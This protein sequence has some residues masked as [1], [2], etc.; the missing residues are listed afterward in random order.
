M[1]AGER[2]DHPLDESRDIVAALH[3]GPLVDD[4]LIELAVIERVERDRGD[5]DRRRR[6]AEHGRR[7]HVVRHAERGAADLGRGAR[8][9]SRAG[10][11]ARRGTGA[12]R[13]LLRAGV[14]SARTVRDRDTIAQP[15]HTKT[16]S[17]TAHDGK[18]GSTRLP[19]AG[20]QLLAFSFE[21]PAPTC[22]LPAE[23]IESGSPGCPLNASCSSP[24]REGWKLGAGS[25]KLNAGR[26]RTMPKATHQR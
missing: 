6:E 7:P 12:R 10:L 26:T 16:A 25:W 5:D 24:E 3:V 4:D 13:A 22:Q 15:S 1:E 18:A 14:T 23:I 17:A 21:L 20:F 9:R 8:A 11:R 2:H 19:V